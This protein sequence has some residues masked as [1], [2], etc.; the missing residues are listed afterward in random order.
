[1]RTDTESLD[2][3]F[4]WH[5]LKLAEHRKNFEHI[6]IFP[7]RH[8]TKDGSFKPIVPPELYCQLALNVLGKF[9][10]VMPPLSK[11][12]GLGMGKSACRWQ[13]ATGWESTK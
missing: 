5:I 8:D 10:A 2:S 7:R 3:M 6:H 9:A 13:N 12:Y 11:I 1:M 4:N